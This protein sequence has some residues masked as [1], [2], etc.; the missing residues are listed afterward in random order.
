[1]LNYFLAGYLKY[2]IGNFCKTNLL[3][4]FIQFYKYLKSEAGLEIIYL[5]FSKFLE[6]NMKLLLIKDSR[7]VTIWGSG[8][9]QIFGWV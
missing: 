9:K 8:G 3:L 5:I 2:N 7:R 1:M 4:N 6:Y